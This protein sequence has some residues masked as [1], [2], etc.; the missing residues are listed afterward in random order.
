MGNNFIFI[1]YFLN[2]LIFDKLAPPKTYDG[3]ETVFAMVVS[4]LI[5]AIIEILFVRLKINCRY[6]IVTL[7]H[8]GAHWLMARLRG[9]SV[10]FELGRPYVKIFDEINSSDNSWIS[11]APIFLVILG[12]TIWD[13]CLAQNLYFWHLTGISIIT[14]ILVYSG[15]PSGWAEKGDIHD[16]D[17]AVKFGERRVN[18]FL[19]C[20]L[21]VSPPIPALY[22]L[23][24]R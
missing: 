4:A 10:D 14:I 8:E 18:N 21:I 6:S 19:V 16:W 11:L 3:A 17:S 7:L 13:W 12:L 2:T 22:Y 23:F 1:V 5:M 9:I 24:L 15:M 20:L